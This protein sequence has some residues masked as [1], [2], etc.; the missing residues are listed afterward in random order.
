MNLGH[1]FN[2]WKAIYERSVHSYPSNANVATPKERLAHVFEKSL[3]DFGS[4]N[5]FANSFTGGSDLKWIGST[6]F[7]TLFLT[8]WYAVCRPCVCS[9]HSR[10]VST[11]QIGLL[12]GRGLRY[13]VVFALAMGCVQVRAAL[14][15]RTQAAA[16][17]AQNPQQARWNWAFQFYGLPQPAHNGYYD[18]EFHRA[19]RPT[20]WITTALNMQVFQNRDAVTILQALSQ[21][22]F[23]LANVLQGG[24]MWQIYEAHGSIRQS[25][26][27]NEGA[28]HFLVF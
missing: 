2:L 14:R 22:W 26:V 25:L 8:A 21:A 27:L 15:Q 17:M 3:F 6:L 13:L 18:A 5:R 4:R 23:D 19:E 11:P 24:A 1:W 20:P 16:T 28:R 7:F 9:D 12:H 10:R